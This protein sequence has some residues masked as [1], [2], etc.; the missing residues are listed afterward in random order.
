MPA[1]YKNVVSVHFLHFLS[2]CICSFKCGRSHHFHLRCLYRVRIIKAC[3]VMHNAEFMATDHWFVVLILKL[4]ATSK[5]TSISNPVAFQIEKINDLD[6]ACDYAETIRIGS[7]CLL[8]SCTLNSCGTHPTV[9]SCRC[10]RVHSREPVSKSGFD[11]GETL[12]Y[13]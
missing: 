3:R 10:G 7:V 6:F 2:T 4:Y 1:H 11:S 13:I 9:K 8:A 5:R 12:E